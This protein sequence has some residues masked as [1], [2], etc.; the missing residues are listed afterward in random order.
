[1]LD[2]EQNPPAPLD[3]LLTEKQLCAWLGIAP[4][5]CSRWRLEGSGPPF[6]ALGPRRLAY[7]RSAVEKWLAS[8]E[9][10]QGVLTPGVFADE[11]LRVREA[12]VR[13]RG[14]A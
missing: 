4:A 8:R 11:T 13:K 12:A 3:N 2:I 7:R 10:S 5:T 1:M 14:V 9:R 6:I